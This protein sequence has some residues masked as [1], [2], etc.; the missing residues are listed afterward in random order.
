[1]DLLPVL[2]G[3][4]GTHKAGVSGRP[5]ERVF[6]TL[7]GGPLNPSNVRNRILTRAAERANERLEWTDPGL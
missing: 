7:T 1:V 3:L 5:D 2:A 6:P 4:L